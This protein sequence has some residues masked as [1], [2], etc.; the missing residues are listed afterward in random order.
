MVGRAQQNGL[1]ILNTEWRHAGVFYDETQRFSFAFSF[2]TYNIPPPHHHFPHCS[3]YLRYLLLSH[4][5]VYYNFICVTNIK[6]R[7]EHKTSAHGGTLGNILRYYD[8][9]DG[10]RDISY[11]FSY[12][13]LLQS[14]L[15]HSNE[16]VHV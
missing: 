4:G 1:L 13:S 15:R 5:F 9:W 8:G 16:H 3:A 11:S 6:Q 12:V 14:T 10:N 7:V 2:I